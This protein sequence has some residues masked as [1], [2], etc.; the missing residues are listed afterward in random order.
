MVLMQRSVYLTVS[1]KIAS[2]AYQSLGFGI[3]CATMRAIRVQV[4]IEAAVART[5]T[6]S[7]GSSSGDG[8]YRKES[9][10]DGSLHCEFL[11]CEESRWEG[12]LG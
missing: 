3:D 5:R 11:V 10:N 8:D 9:G 7:N 2:G 4:W 1:V 12:G 6:T